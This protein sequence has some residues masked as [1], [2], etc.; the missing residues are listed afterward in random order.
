MMMTKREIHLSSQFKKD[1]RRARKQ[2]KD[3]QLLN[4]IVTMLANDEPLDS[5]F[6]DHALSG[7]WS[8]FRECHLSP[9]WL[10]VYRK[11]DQGQLLLSLARAA[12]HSNLNF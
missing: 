10:L 3:L 9:D 2:G 12:S 8:G 6:R 4:T 1:V 7:N 11:S 5:K